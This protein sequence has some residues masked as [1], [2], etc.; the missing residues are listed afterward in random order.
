LYSEDDR[1]NDALITR[2]DY[3]NLLKLAREVKNKYS[4]KRKQSY[5]RY[6]DL[7]EFASKIQKLHDKPITKTVNN[8]LREFVAVYFNL[9]EDFLEKKRNDDGDNSK[10]AEVPT[11][12][13]E[14]HRIAS[15]LV[16]Y[17]FNSENKTNLR[18]KAKGD[19]SVC[20]IFST[21]LLRKY[22][23]INN[24]NYYNNMLLQ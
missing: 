20:T 14:V 4:R 5:K 19:K 3:K 21:S 13:G 9:R 10:R 12:S 18:M 11:K 1:G 16:G 2:E 23:I 6:I 8:Y 15:F 24:Y 17:N 7:E 22:F